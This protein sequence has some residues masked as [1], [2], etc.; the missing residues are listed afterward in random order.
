[1]LSKNY[2]K[3]T[4]TWYENKTIFF[5]VIEE[6]KNDDIKLTMLSKNYNLIESKKVWMYENAR[7]YAGDF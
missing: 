7:D 1:M 4:F 2:K 5:S 3:K 6:K